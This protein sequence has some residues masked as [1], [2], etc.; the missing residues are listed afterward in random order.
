MKHT[1]AGLRGF[2]LG[3]VL[4]ALILTVPTPLGAAMSKKI[5]VVYNNVK[6]VVDGRAVTPKD[7]KGN[8][9]E[10]FIYRGTTYLPVRAAAD[11]ITGGTKAVVWDQQ[12]ATIYIGEKP[13]GEVVDMATMV[14]YYA[15]QG[16]EQ[17]KSFTCRQEEYHPFNYFHNR[18][19]VYLLK[20]K[21][22][23]FQAEFA[24]ASTDPNYVQELTFYDPDSKTELARFSAA[25]GEA[26]IPISLDV[27]GMDKLGIISKG[28]L[29]NATLTGF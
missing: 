29:F 25:G 4:T 19:N 15:P 8:V 21:Y 10:P 13:T 20:G 27:T 18:S 28:T 14:P 16:F 12:T 5:D 7:A 2:A 1:R 17:N 26:P 22:T 9:V 11:A 3:V 24:N 6:L 23:T